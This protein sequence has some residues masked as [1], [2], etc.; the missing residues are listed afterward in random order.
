MTGLP[1]LVRSGDPDRR[2]VNGLTA[3]QVDKEVRRRADELRAL[4]VA[5]PVALRAPNGADWL[6]EFL[7]LLEAGASPLLVSED[8]PDQELSRLLDLARDGDR[9][10]RA[11]LVPTSGSTGLPALVTRTE[12]SLLREGERYRTTLALDGCDRVLLPLPLCHAYALAW[13]TA[14]LV[15]GAEL[16]AVPPAAL[17][18]IEDELAQGATII[19]LVPTLARLLATRRL[20]R[21]GEIPPPPRMAMV[22]AGPVDQRLEDS[23][24]AAFG[25]GTS[26]NYG[27]TE[28]GTL[29]AGLA[30]LP[31]LCVGRPLDGVAYRIVDER[32]RPCP[33]GRPGVLEVELDDA[34]AWHSTR[35]L[36]V[37]DAEGRV[38]MLGRQSSAIRRGAR[39]VAPLEVENVLREHPAVRDVHVYAR[40]GRFEGEDAIVAEVEAAPGLDEGEL[41]AFARE[42][43]APH[44]V[45][46]EIV[47]TARLDRTMTGKVRA[48]PRYRLAGPDV[49]AA[50][51]RGYKAAELLFAL[52]DLGVLDRL[53]G[54]AGTEEIAARLGLSA[55]E[56]D[57]ALAI[58]ARL[59]LVV[60]GTE[61]DPETGPYLDLEAALS[62]GWTARETIADTLRHGRRRLD[63]RAPADEVVH[64]Y[65]AAMN[66]PQT[67]GR[68]RLGRRLAAVPPG[69]HVLEV[70]AGPGRYLAEI[71]AADP[72][73]TGELLRLGRFSGPP[74]PGITT[75]EDPPAGAYDLCVVA[76]GIHGPAPGDDLA[77]L[78]TRLRPGGRL[79]VDDV[80]LPP[81]GA[82]S[83]LGIDWLTHGGWS[84]PAVTDLTAGLAA[85]GGAVVRDARIGASPCHLVLATEGS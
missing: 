9:P 12:A 7:A 38:F 14:A 31:S 60:T 71:L 28:T 78:L 79:L 72:A 18:A 19:A 85:A 22:G 84:W 3:A 80:F 4:R 61:G 13:A 59:G 27:S 56:L 37:R 15:A 46:T 17:T 1:G 77:W 30:D 36:A 55:P 45:P 67:A 76:N 10:E 5:G 52:R 75:T 57:W 66:G 11:I 48:R 50:A 54:R 8:A 41:L 40:A 23:F 35:D 49:V 29:F 51:V 43:L 21:G 24:R 64:A 2:V 53:D 68:T 26:R 42:R 44:K 83:E 20:R 73:A 25:C 62:R 32:G 81:E 69:A 70:S 39:W 16:R 33:D 34:G 47:R 74:A 63:V 58:A 6:V 82:G 65:Q